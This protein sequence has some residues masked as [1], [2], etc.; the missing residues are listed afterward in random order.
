MA[1]DVLKYKQH[2]LEYIS[3]VMPFKILNKV[4]R[5]L[6]YNDKTGEGYQRK[7]NETH[8]NRI[9]NDIIS[10][11]QGFLLPTSIIL[12]VDKSV[13]MKFL[14]EDSDKVVL[15]DEKIDNTIFNIV[16]G[17]HRLKGLEKALNTLTGNDKNII[18]DYSF[19]VIC[20]LTDET[21]RSVEVDIFV[22]INSKSKRVSTDLA[23]LARFNY[24]TKEKS[25][26]NDLK[27]LSEHL[28]LIVG[29]MM[30]ER[31]DY[32]LWNN[33]IKFDI[34]A[35]SKL[36]V[37]GVSAFRKSITG[38]CR[39]YINKEHN[40]LLQLNDVEL[41]EKCSEI[42]VPITN[43]I[44]DCWSYLQSEKWNGC[45]KKGSSMDDYGEIVDTYFNHNF[46]LQ[47]PPGVYA[48]HKIIED[49]YAE[50]GSFDLTLS[51]FKEL[52]K[53]SKLLSSDWKMGGKFSGL[54]SQSGFNKI[55]SHILNIEETKF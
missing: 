14:R 29:R 6:E 39:L 24:R 50:H 15:L 55:K 45:F 31:N 16:D 43:F 17:Q 32:L 18:N 52:I 30:N 9:K 27:T 20:V 38:L 34:H 54:N 37:I 36:G 1:L 7:P 19:N 28:A 4:S 40:V 22:D 44:Y 35:D 53:S 46:Y 47:K 25:L 10:N 21:N 49:L 48:I 2:N 33:A 11:L 42:S 23:E 41:I 5:V 12:G 26:T 51:A 13:I 8:I 3:F